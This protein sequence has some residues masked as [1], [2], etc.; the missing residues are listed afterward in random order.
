MSRHSTVAIPAYTNERTSWAPK[1][2]NAVQ[3]FSQCHVN[4]YSGSR[5][6]GFS[7]SEILN[8]VISGTTKKTK[9][10]ARPGRAMRYGTLRPARRLR[11]SEASLATIRLR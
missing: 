8:S 6:S 1:S 2:S 9:R 7:E 4:S 10:N 11:S 3:K 5:G